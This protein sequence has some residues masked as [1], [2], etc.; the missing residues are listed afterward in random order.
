MDR[1]TGKLFEIYGGLYPKLDVDTLCVFQKR[2]E[3]IWYPLKIVLQLE[4]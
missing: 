2:E 1:K 4:A 3:E